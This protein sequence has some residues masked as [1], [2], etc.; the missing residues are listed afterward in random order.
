[1]N[2]P[3]ELIEYL[4]NGVDDAKSIDF[5]FDGM[6]SDVL[7]NFDVSDDA[8]QFVGPIIK[9][10]ENNPGVDFGQPGALVHFVEKFYRR[11]Y[12]DL[13]VSS[14]ER[15]PTVHTVWMLNRIINDPSCQN[16]KKY[17]DFL[18][19]IEKQDDVGEEVK[20]GIRFF[21]IP[22]DLGLVSSPRNRKTIAPRASW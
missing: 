9:F 6:A 14:L 4:Q 15:H 18:R 12:E 17:I 10:I 5:D 21:W 19:R 20:E 16:R 2:S 13:L 8:F 3:E 1:M 22:R 11:G 7:K